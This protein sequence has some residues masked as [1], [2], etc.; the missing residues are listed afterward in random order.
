MNKE[1]LITLKNDFKKNFKDNIASRYWNRRT[2]KILNEL[3]K[4]G[5]NNF[6]GYNSGIGIGFADHRNLDIRNVL[7]RK[8][9]LISQI[10]NFKIFKP[11]YSKQL[12]L[13]KYYSDSALIFKRFFFEN[14]KISKN[15]LEKYNFDNTCNHGVL[16]KITYKNNEVAMLYL[17]MANRIDFINT[18]VNLNSIKSFCEIGSGFGANIHFILSNFKNIKKIICIDIFPTIFILTEYLQS[19]YGDRVKDYTY[20]KDKN[21]IIFKDDDELEIYCVPNW[22]VHKIKTKIDHLHNAHSFVEMS[23]DQLTLYNDCIFKKY[24]ESASFLFYNRTI[25]ERTLDYKIVSE[26][27]S[28]NFKKYDLPLIEDFKI[29]DTLLIYNK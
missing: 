14:S 16:D 11:I 12:K 5:L 2:N 28:V 21:E 15:L 20:F 18:K 27:F 25:E 6:R 9:K 19:I 8:E 24:V 4:K 13:T 29:S 22:E 7:G 3:E 10:F 17:L 1:L 26:K 23:S